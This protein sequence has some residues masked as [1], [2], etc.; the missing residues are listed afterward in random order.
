MS[1]GLSFMVKVVPKTVSTINI[2]R[3]HR[4][5]SNG[6]PRTILADLFRPIGFRNIISG[7]YKF[8][9]P[10]TVTN[11]FDDRKKK[12]TLLFWYATTDV[13]DVAPSIIYQWLF[14]DNYQLSCMFCNK[15]CPFIYNCFFLIFLSCFYVVLTYPSLFTI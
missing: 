14:A 11:V 5:F 10:N 6:S 13:K 2:H 12:T 8:G 7:F 9:S 1:A 4:H 3:T 15:H